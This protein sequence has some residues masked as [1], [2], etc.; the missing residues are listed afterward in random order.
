MAEKRSCVENSSATNNKIQKVFHEDCF[1]G[2]E[3]ESN[4][5]C[6]S[7]SE[8]KMD[9]DTDTD[10][11]HD[12]DCDDTD[13]DPGDNINAMAANPDPNVSI[14]DLTLVA[15]PTKL[16]IKKL[17]KHNKDLGKEY[18]THKNK[19]VASKKVEEIENCNQ[20]CHT[21]INI[22]EQKKIF[23]TYWNL[24]SYSKRR[25]YLCGLIDI[26][27][28]KSV[29]ISETSKPRYRPYNYSYHFEIN[30]KKKESM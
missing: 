13:Y 2:F 11:F 8:S 5:D 26:A 20:L 23:K 27:T 10:P 28:T 3:T 4:V 9:S 29:R 21:K 24:G 14:P 19:I 18:V 30:G 16:A 6:E 7:V 12:T 25:Q 15:A 17:N 22:A 1:C